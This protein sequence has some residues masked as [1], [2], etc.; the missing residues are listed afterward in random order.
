MYN[1]YYCLTHGSYENLKATVMLPVRRGLL[2]WAGMGRNC[3]PAAVIGGGTR[4]TSVRRGAETSSRQ[5][6]G[7][8]WW[9]FPLHFR[10]WF[11]K[12]LYIYCLRNHSVYGDLKW[13]AG[14]WWKSINIQIFLCSVKQSFLF[15]VEVCD[16]VTWAQNFCSGFALSP[17]VFWMAF[18]NELPWQ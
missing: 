10:Q 5:L 7:L 17:P 11:F 1:A 16:Y 3:I 14:V 13:L 18:I 8:Y 9:I 6:Q 15:L 4:S 2:K 12:P